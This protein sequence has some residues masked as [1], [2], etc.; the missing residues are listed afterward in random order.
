MDMKLLSTNKVSRNNHVYTGKPITEI[1]TN[2]FFTVDEKWIVKYWNKSAERILGVQAKDI[3]GKN[4][5]EEF[6]GRIPI[7]FYIFYQKA[8]LQD[9]PVHFEEY[10]AEA[11]A[12]F[13]VVTYHCDDTLSVSFKKSGQ[14]VANPEQQL[15]TLNELYRFVTEV[16][17]DCLWEW[18]FQAKEIFWIDGGH[19]RVFGYPIENAIIPQIFWES[20]I[21]P[22]D[23]AR[24]LKTLHDCMT[25]GLD[26]I[27]EEE[28][29]FKRADGEYAFVHDRGHV[30][31]NVRKEAFRMIGATQDI[32]EKVALQ[33]KLVMLHKTQQRE[34][35]E[36]V[37]A[38]QER[39][40]SDIGREMHDNL[41][42]VLAVAKM[43]IQMSKKSEKDR[44][45]YLDNSCKFISN[46]IEDIRNISK[47]LVIPD[48][49]IIGLF[50][51]IKNLLYDLAKVHTINFEFYKNDIEENELDEKLQLTIYRIVQEQMNNILKHAEATHATI[52]L[53]REKGN[54]VLYISDNGKGCD[55]AYEKQGL[56]IINIKSRVELYNGSVSITSKP[57][58]GYELKVLLPLKALPEPD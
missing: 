43:Y 27:W 29:R 2:G 15:V 51:N 58:E 9:I 32:T 23:K 17:N 12:W 3:V 36:A 19:K 55:M 52:N 35:T 18:D 8:F 14:Q 11:E 20:R 53:T 10:W 24:I 44:D 7:E 28:Y 41:N 5:W 30:F 50:D 57:G 37:L 47:H 6:V 54:M 40:R 49:H 39:E 25:E 45:M 21:H 38:A 46:V 22:E 56:G 26:C 13:E 48:A 33:N 4:L 31:Y 1:I 16:T 42:Q 34:L